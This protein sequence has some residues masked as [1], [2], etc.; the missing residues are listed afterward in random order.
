M[1]TALPSLGLKPTLLADSLI[2]HM[3]DVVDRYKDRV[4][5][6][7]LGVSTVK[8]AATASELPKTAAALAQA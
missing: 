2:G 6:A 8:W 5:P 4:D 7:A 3:F 1:H